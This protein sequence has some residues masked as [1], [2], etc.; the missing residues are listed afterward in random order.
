MPLSDNSLEED[1]ISNEHLFALDDYWYDNGE[2][3]GFYNVWHDLPTR[4]GAVFTGDIPNGTFY[5]PAGP[6][7]TVD[8]FANERKVRFL[9]ELKRGK[10][11]SND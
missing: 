1:R 7:V 2:E 3:E 9:K 4:I 8:E 6:Y 5:L 11:A 10:G